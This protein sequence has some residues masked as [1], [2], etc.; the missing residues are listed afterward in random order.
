MEKA[1]EKLGGKVPGG[2]DCPDL[3]SLE[4]AVS[5]QL[6]AQTDAITIKVQLP[7]REFARDLADALVDVLMEH[8]KEMN[9]AATRTA[10]EYLEEQLEVSNA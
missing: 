5:A 9:S 7:D 4:K 6:I 8:N 3:D 2:V 1:L 10:R